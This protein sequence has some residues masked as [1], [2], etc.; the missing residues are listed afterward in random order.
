MTECTAIVYYM[1]LLKK[2]PIFNNHHFLRYQ[3]FFI[4]FFKSRG[5]NKYGT[6]N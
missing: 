2:L 4:Y 6:A 3:I 1:D 5:R